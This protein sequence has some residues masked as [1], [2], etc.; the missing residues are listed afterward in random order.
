MYLTVNFIL[1]TF[2]SGKKV[3]IV[4]RKAEFLEE[5]DR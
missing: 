4:S 2:I 1:I 3:E 5:D